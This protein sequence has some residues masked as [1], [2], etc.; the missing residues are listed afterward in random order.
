MSD[1][2]TTDYRPPGVYTTE[3]SAPTVGAVGIG[4]TVV[5]IVGPSVGYMTATEAVVLEGTTNVRLAHRGVIQNSVLVTK[6]DGTTADLTD[7]YVLTVGN[8]DDATASTGDDTTDIKRANSSTIADGE[9]V[10]VSYRYTDESY[11]TPKRFTDFA[12]VKDTYGAPLDTSSGDIISPLTFA[13]KCAFDNGASRIILLATP[14]SAT[15]VD[16]DDLTDGYAKL[17]SMEEVTIVVPLPVGINGSTGS[18]G[19]TSS[20]GTAVANHVQSAFNQGI[21]RIAILGYETGVTRAPDDL[22]SG[23]DNKRVAITW[24]ARM[25]YFNAF[26]NKSQEVGGYYAA[27][28]EAGRLSTLPVNFPL[29]R[30]PVRGLSIGSTVAQNITR[31]DR[32]AWSKA[33]VMVLETN[34]QGILV[35]RH[36]V[37]TDP[38]SVLTSELSITR[39]A[40][41]MIRSCTDALEAADLIGSPIVD[42]TAARIKGI[43]QNVLETIKDAEIIYDYSG[44]SVRQQSVDPSV[45]EVRF[46]YRPTYP[47]NYINIVFGVDPTTGDVTDL[48]QEA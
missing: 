3:E 33:G 40:D 20:I 29:T 30:K 37:S 31:S 8:G 14:G 39:Q 19:D 11:F 18:P 5:A 26:L 43:I 1:F 45:I 15:S 34:S 42:E 24:P 16:K 36:G 2:F 48:S 21:R 41:T 46:Q 7:D 28:A 17:L 6:A 47:L 4:P 23:I 27:A 10:I 44:L 22:A 13:A 38:T 25:S 32:D 12:A 9:T 35:V